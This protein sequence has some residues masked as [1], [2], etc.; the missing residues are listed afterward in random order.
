VSS[1]VNIGIILA[2]G[3]GNLTFNDTS[4][5]VDGAIVHAD[6]LSNVSHVDTSLVV[7]GA[8]LHADLLSNMTHGLSNVVLADA[9]VHTG[10]SSLNSF[11]FTNVESSKLSLVQSAYCVKHNCFSSGVLVSSELILRVSHD[12]GIFWNLVVHVI[13][14]IV[15]IILAGGFGHLTFND[16]SLVVDGAIVHADLL[17]NVSHL[18]SNVVLADAIV[19]ADLLSNVTGVDTSNVVDGAISGAGSGS[20]SSLNSTKV[21]III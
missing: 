11:V 2:G 1:V 7:D 16:T 14:V 18:L 4:L 15:G 21:D 6:L 19:H 20:L 13:V 8:V 10:H 17:S 9:I 5:V 3:F 12:D